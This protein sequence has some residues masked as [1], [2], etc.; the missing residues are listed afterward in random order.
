MIYIKLEDEQQAIVLMNFINIAVKT[1]GLEAA[2]AGLFFKSRI[3]TAIADYRV[4]LGRAD[5]PIENSNG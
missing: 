5:T 2:D 4:T 1:V 3:D